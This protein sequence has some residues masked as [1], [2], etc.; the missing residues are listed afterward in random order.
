LL[1]P[2]KVIFDLLKKGITPSK[3][4]LSCALGVTLGAFPILG[5]TTLLCLLVGQFLGLNQVAIQT[6]NY[7]M[8]PVQ[9]VL[10]PVF[11]RIGEMIYQAEPVAIDPRVLILEFRKDVPGFL[12]QYGMAGVHA[13]SA[14]FIIGPFIFFIFYWIFLTVFRRAM[15]RRQ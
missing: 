5:S 15:P 13:I 11:V 1:N 14:W 10:V 12:K 7:F 3:L 2:K 9:L 4:A 8:T 6:V